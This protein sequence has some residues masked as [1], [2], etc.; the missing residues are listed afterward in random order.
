MMTKEFLREVEIFKALSDDQRAKLAGLARAETFKKGDVIFRE[1]E[2]G[3]RLYVV[4]SGVVDI[5]RA[6]CGD[7]RF[8]RL[9]RL[10]RGE[11]F[12]ELALVEDSPHSATAVAGVCPETRVGVW[13]TTT[14]R[15]L[16]SEDPAL[17]NVVLRALVGK[18]SK[19]LRS[20]SEAV[21][22]LLRTLDPA[23]PH[24]VA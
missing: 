22:T 10:E 3:G 11:V 9:T 12:G 6:A 19:R 7:G 4:I 20:A 21:L 5:G 17:A 1:R 18:L 24:P 2:P 23:G 16:L 8:V 14:L 15:T 13:E